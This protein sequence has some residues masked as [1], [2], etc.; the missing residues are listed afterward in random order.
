MAAVV[1]HTPF[2]CLYPCVAV[3]DSF[4]SSGSSLLLWAALLAAIPT[5]PKP[6]PP[7]SLPSLSG[8]LSIANPPPIKTPVPSFNLS[9]PSS[10]VTIYHFIFLSFPSSP[11]SKLFENITPPPPPP[12]VWISPFSSFLQ[13]VYIRLICLWQKD[14]PM[15]LWAS[16]RTHFEKCVERIKVRPWARTSSVYLSILNSSAPKHRQTDA[17]TP[18]PPLSLSSS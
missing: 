2:H 9:S 5:K 12:P 17:R 6:P 14:A 16:W 18:P 7:V 13:P 3:C 10:F 11:F 8:S 1:S 15:L 4:H